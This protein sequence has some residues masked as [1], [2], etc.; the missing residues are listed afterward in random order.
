[1]ARRTPQGE[2]LAVWVVLAADLLAVL[3]VYSVLDPSELYKVSGEG[4]GGGLSRALVLLNFPMALAAIPLVLLAMDSL[5]RRAWLVGAPALALCAFVAV[6]GVIDPDDLDA[7]L[8]NAIPAL[9]VVLALGLTIAAGGTAG[10]AFAPA[11]RGDRARIAVSAVLVVVSLPWIAAELGKH[12][13]QGIFLTTEL[14]AEPHQPPAAAV[15]LGH[16]HGM[17]GL[18]LAT[19]A[20]LLSRSSL[21]LPTL[22]R[23]YAVL[24]SLMLSYGLANI[25]NDSWHEQVVK[26]GWTSTDIPGAT[27]PAANLTWA[28]VLVATGVL[29]A[30]GFG[31]PDERGV[32]G[33]NHLR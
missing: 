27:L 14:Y 21:L 23:T 20:L 19:A 31:R 13:P 8:V 2:G 22:R 25:A 32:T 28:V 12:F 6:P 4:L 9:G 5:S 24:L 3:V 30:L 1:M 33:D 26:R 10:W 29:Y 7:R 18:L 15:H 17:S 11:R 16:H